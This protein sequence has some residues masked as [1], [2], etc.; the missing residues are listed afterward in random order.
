MAL[1]AKAVKNM[2]IEMFISNE[3]KDGWYNIW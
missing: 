2:S 1:Q 3:C